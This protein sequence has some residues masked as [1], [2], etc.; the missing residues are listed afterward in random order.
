MPKNVFALTDWAQKFSLTLLGDLGRF[1]DKHQLY[2][3]GALLLLNSIN[4]S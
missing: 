2:K 1:I 4:K 3:S